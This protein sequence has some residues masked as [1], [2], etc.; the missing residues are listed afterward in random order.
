MYRTMDDLWT[1]TIRDLFAN[2][3]EIESRV[4]KTKELVGYSV[5]LSHVSQTFLLNKRRKL[6]PAYG[7]A[8]VL[9]YLSKTRSIEMIKAY[10][11]QYE[12]FA[13][14]GVAHG[15]YGYRIDNNAKENQLELLVE[16][17][18]AKPSSRQAIITL[19]EASDLW[20]S[21]K[22]ERKDLPCTLSLQFLIRKNRL[23]LVTTMRSND[24]WLGLPYDVFAFTCLQWLVAS[25]LDIEPGTY[26]HQAGSMHLYEKNWKAAE[27][28]IGRNTKNFLDNPNYPSKYERLEHEWNKMIPDPWQ[29]DV[30]RAINREQSIRKGQ[31]NLDVPYNRMLHDCL[32]CC[33]SE[34]SVFAAKPKSPILREAIKNV[35]K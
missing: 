6:S 21:V 30:Q 4:G 9:W 20:H 15:A 25:V 17:L 24:A 2:G 7:C 28:A 1:A 29:E 19:W 10:A 11:P 35:K 31:S 13:E 32:L 3:N 26:T 5:D 27:E 34:W 14:D 18:R 33:A 12:K 16:H 23:H 22:D 8:E